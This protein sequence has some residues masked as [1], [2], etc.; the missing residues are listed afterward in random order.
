MSGQRL[1]CSSTCHLRPD[2]ILVMRTRSGDRE[3]R[4]SNRAPSGVDLQHCRR[5]HHPRDAEIP[6]EIFIKVLTRLSS[7]E[8]NDNS[9]GFT[10]SW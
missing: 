1:A 9:P 4:T 3:P 8:G 2:Q 6:Q 7:F 5:I 10:A